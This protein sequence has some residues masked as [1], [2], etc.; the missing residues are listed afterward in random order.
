V[1]KRLNLP[2]AGNLLG[3]LAQATTSAPIV[4]Y[5]AAM[6][7]EHPHLALSSRTDTRREG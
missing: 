5:V 6:L 1:Y 2:G 7:S 4:T 3:L